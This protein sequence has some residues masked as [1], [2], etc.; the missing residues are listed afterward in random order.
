MGRAE[1][2][3]RGGEV[4]SDVGKSSHEREQNAEADRVPGEQRSIPKMRPS[5]SEQ[6]AR[7][8]RTLWLG[9]GRQPAPDGGGHGEIRQ[10]EGDER[11]PPWGVVGDETGSGAS[12]KASDHGAADI[13]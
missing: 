3:R 13:G 6:S 8:V 5:G 1:Q 2:E 4:E 11:Q 12:A 9:V 10:T 7:G